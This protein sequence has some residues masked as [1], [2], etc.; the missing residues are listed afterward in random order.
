MLRTLLALCLLVFS[1][2]IHAQAAPKTPIGEFLAGNKTHRGIGIENPS[3]VHLLSLSYSTLNAIRDRIDSSEEKL[4]KSLPALEREVMEV[5]LRRARVQYRLAWEL[6]G[7]LIDKSLHDFDLRGAKS[8]LGE[9]VFQ[10][11]EEAN[12]KAAR[13]KKIKGHVL[14]KAS[15]LFLGSLHFM[16]LK[17]EPVVV[18]GGGISEILRKDNAG[19]EPSDVDTKA[20]AWLDDAAYALGNPDAGKNFVTN[21]QIPLWTNVKIL[22]LSQAIVKGFKRL[23]NRTNVLDID[24]NKPTV[25]QKTALMKLVLASRPEIQT[26]AKN[27]SALVLFFTH[28]LGVLIDPYNVNTHDSY[29]LMRASI[30][31]MFRH[32]LDIDGNEN[33]TLEQAKNYQPLGQALPNYRPVAGMMTGIQK[34]LLQNYLRE[35]ETGPKLGTPDRTRREQ[36]AEYQIFHGNLLRD[37]FGR[38]VRHWIYPVAKAW[39]REDPRI[40]ATVKVNGKAEGRKADGSARDEMAQLQDGDLWMEKGTGMG[41]DLIS[42]ATVPATPSKRTKAFVEDSSIWGVAKQKLYYMWSGALGWVEEKLQIA[43]RPEWLGVDKPGKGVD[44]TGTSHTGIV[45][46]F[47]DPSY[48]QLSRADFVDAFPNLM[49]QAWRRHGCGHGHS[50]LCMFF[51]VRKSWA[52]DYVNRFSLYDAALKKRVADQLNRLRS[53]KAWKSWWPEFLAVDGTNDTQRAYLMCRKL[54]TESMAFKTTEEMMQDRDFYRLG[55]DYCDSVFLLRGM[56]N[57]ENKI[58]VPKIH[59]AKAGES[60]EAADARLVREMG[61][62]VTEVANDIR[63][64][65]GDMKGFGTE[66]DDRFDSFTKAK[67]YCSEKADLAYRLAWGR[68][69]YPESKF[70]ESIRKIEDIV[71]ESMVANITGGFIKVPWGDKDT[72]YAPKGILEVKSG[73]EV[74]ETIG[75]MRRGFFGVND[76]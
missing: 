69:V 56:R 76:E 26:D 46:V 4:K 5:R 65:A 11:A 67:L 12:E 62:L 22:P 61:K 58:L 19:L 23:L 42:W 24:L 3:L 73:R 27:V 9:E 43:E 14:E 8:K 17:N 66:F 41:S 15:E 71:P 37:L 28:S 36:L 49:R 32:I 75:E 16:A 18:P 40:G 60:A 57:F 21:Q 50:R 7:I 39:G 68:E 25:E 35:V 59:Q 51:R 33:W 13:D 54:T 44:Y 2:S 70:K 30:A 74:W 52:R 55:H 1:V 48:P 63:N 34:R 45:A 6:L 20:F 47:E 10:E 38:D 29:E 53:K 72:V 64:Q 31:V